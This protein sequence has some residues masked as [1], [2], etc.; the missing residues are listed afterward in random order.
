MRATAALVSTRSAIAANVATVITD[1]VSDQLD[2]LGAENESE[3]ER[4]ISRIR[5][6]GVMGVAR[7]GTTDRGAESQA[8]AARTMM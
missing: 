7:S 8:I 3:S 5:S 1:R 2:G 4:S 6:D